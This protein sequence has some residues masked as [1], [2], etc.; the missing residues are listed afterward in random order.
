LDAF[1]VDVKVTVSPAITEVGATESVVVVEA[2]TRLV[3][4]AP[5][6]LNSATATAT[7]A[8]TVRMSAR[9]WL[10]GLLDV[11]ADTK[12]NSVDGIDRRGC[13]TSA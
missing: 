12:R 4:D 7:N 2:E 5:P 11:A 1:T 13:V 10:A 8:D 6:T 3:A 9:Q